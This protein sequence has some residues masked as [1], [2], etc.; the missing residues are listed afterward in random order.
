MDG[1]NRALDGLG[2]YA[3]R[4][5]LNPRI[6]AR[7]QALCLLLDEC[8][9]DGTA[10]RSDERLVVFTEYKTT[11]D[12]LAAR[13]TTRHSG[14]R[15]VRSLFGGMDDAERDEVKRAFNDPADPVRILVATDAAAE[16][17]NLQET[18]RYLLHFD[19]P[20]N[21][22]RLEQRNGRLDRH[23]Q[24]RDVVV[25]HFTTDDD[26]DLAFL[27]YVVSKVHAIREDLGSVG[28]LFDRA[29]ERRLIGG[30][31]REAVL[32]DLNAGVEATRGRAEMPRSRVLDT[33]E[34][35]LARLRA[36]ADEVDLDPE[37]IRETLQAALGA[38]APLEG[39]DDRGGYR[40]GTVPP[41]WQAVVD[42]ALRLAQRD[43][44]R[45]PIPKLLFDPARLVRTTN[46][47]PVFRP[48]SDLALLH[49]GHPVLHQALN[50]FARA[51]FPGADAAHAT[52][53]TVRRSPVPEG[54]DALLVLTVEELA[55]NELRETFHHWIRTLRLPIRGGALEAALPHVAA[56]DLRLLGAAPSVGDIR[57]ARERWDEVEADVR[58][59]VTTLADELTARLRLALESEGRT[60]LAEEQERF[61][62]RQG[63]VS[64][65][66]EGSTLSRLEREI[67][68]AEA[69]LQQG[70]LF[71][72]EGRIAELERTKAEKE[73][74]VRRRKVHYEELRAQLQRERERVVHQLVPRRYKQRGYA[75]VLPVTIEIRLPA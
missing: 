6:D 29:F 36:L 55:V 17:L 67:R 33:G 7:F 30:E 28:D 41:A 5:G 50:R 24:A 69:E 11:L 20:W 64:R 46:G 74:E 44:A 60:A 63:E 1:I 42:D 59:L 43:G 53:W 51:R 14:P 57:K 49:L 10:F 37:S 4:T 21:P 66:I 62:A 54:A 34:P 75:Q 27:G 35:D 38:S 23:G 45:G 72:A 15:S 25:H 56:R 32:R 26:A 16:G 31:D 61:Q 8:L 52:R 3:A 22:A 13:L 2:I 47:R 39:P 40:L 68:E 58:A 19:V 48:E 12:Y 18:A 65:L 71:D 70:T 73:E 9:L